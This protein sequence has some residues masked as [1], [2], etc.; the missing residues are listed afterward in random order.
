MN[1]TYDHPAA[2]R[3]DGSAVPVNTGGSVE[4]DILPALTSDPP[5]RSMLVVQYVVAVIAAVCAVLLSQAT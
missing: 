1:E 5:D 3:S 2:D 4:A